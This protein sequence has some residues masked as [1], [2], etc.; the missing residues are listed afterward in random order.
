MTL[1]FAIWNKERALIGAEGRLTN[2]NDG[3]ITSDYLQKIIIDN[4]KV[5]SNSSGYFYNIED[6]IIGVKKFIEQ[7]EFEKA[8]PTYYFYAANLYN[9]LENRKEAMNCIYKALEIAES[10]FRPIEVI[11][12]YYQI[13]YYFA[14]FQK[15]YPLALTYLPANPNP[16]KP[17]SK[18]N[19][20]V[21]L[22][23]DNTI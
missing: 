23:N 21:K 2:K 6:L 3:S 4:K 10:H 17:E 15:N 22:N 9:M 20:N 13:A 16:A 14:K 12:S 8:K 5:L 11:K 18:R 19:N 1:I 7:I